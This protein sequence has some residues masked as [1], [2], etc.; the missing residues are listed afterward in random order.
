[1]A[2][3]LMLPL[4]N[5]SISEIFSNSVF[6][7]LSNE[8]S[9]IFNGLWFIVVLCII[10]MLLCLDYKKHY[11]II[12]ICL[13]SVLLILDVLGIRFGGRLYISKLIFSFPF[14]A[15]G[16]YLKEHN[17]IPCFHRKRYLSL[18]IITFLCIALVNKC[19]DIYSTNYGYGYCIAFIGAVLGSLSLYSLVDFLPKNSIIQT[20]S[21][22]TLIILGLHAPLLGLISRVYPEF[23]KPIY[24]ILAPLIVILLCY[25][26]IAFC[27]KYCK[28]MLG[29]FPRSENLYVRL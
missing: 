12:S 27:L 9:P 14:V 8:K 21:S 25:P 19:C 10:K 5:Y 1:M 23:L 29:R 13:L 2:I 17:I 4:N 15:F 28:W 18:I 3:I 20:I 11:K 22:G 16:L 7:S 6:I 26:V 24:F